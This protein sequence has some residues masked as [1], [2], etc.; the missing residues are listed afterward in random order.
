MFELISRRGVVA[1]VSFV[2]HCM[3][4]VCLGKNWHRKLQSY[5]RVQTDSGRFAFHFC[6]QQGRCQE[7]YLPVP[8]LYKE[9]G[10]KLEYKCL[11]YYSWILLARLVTVTSTVLGVALGILGW[12]ESY[13]L[14]MG[15]IWAGFTAWFKNFSAGNTG[16]WMRSYGKQ[17]DLW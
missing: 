4:A 10:Q 3:Q 12:D 7:S 2:Y 17:W 11:I 5:P 15:V 14:W 9:R 1:I 8:R 13:A 16:I 6:G